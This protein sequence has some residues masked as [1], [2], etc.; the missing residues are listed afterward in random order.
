MGEQP[1][2]QVQ[3]GQAVPQLREVP[4]QHREPALAAYVNGDRRA[5]EILVRAIEPV[6]HLAIQPYAFLG[7]HVGDRATVRGPRARRR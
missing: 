1:R 5:I 6:A 4:A 7:E 3:L 2:A